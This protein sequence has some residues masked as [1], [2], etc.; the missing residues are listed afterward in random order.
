[1]IRILCVS[2][3]GGVGKSSIAQQVAATYLL[4]R[5]GAAHLVELDDQN[6]DSQWLKKSKIRTSQIVV[7]GDPKMAVLDVFENASGKS[8]VLDLGN[9]VADSAI[10]AMGRSKALSRFDL[11]L[12]PV[13]DVGQDLI[14]CERT[15]NEIRRYEPSATVVMVCN[16]ISVR[17]QSNLRVLYGRI[18]D[19]AEDAGIEVLVMPFIEG[20]G[21]SREFAT[22]LLEVAADSE[23]LV[24]LFH[25]KGVELE[26]ADKIREARNCMAMVEL[27]NNAVDASGAIEKIHSQIDAILACNTAEAANG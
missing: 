5:E 25:K 7:D 21:Q 11:I 15:I 3:K 22:T 8:F 20:Y 17:R 9:Q 26:K 1:M 14:N 10:E 24:E 19:Y 27:I 6:Q 2:T 18:F 12:V 16:G 23:K 13:R 4:K